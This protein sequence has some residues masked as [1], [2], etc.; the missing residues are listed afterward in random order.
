MNKDLKYLF[1]LV[2]LIFL[3]LGILVVV[4]MDFSNKIEIVNDKKIWES[5]DNNMSNVKSIMDSI[6]DDSDT[7]IWWSLKDVKLKDESYIRFLNQLVAD[8]RM[9]YLNLTSD[10][11]TDSNIMSNYRDKTYIYKSDLVKINNSLSSDNMD[12]NISYDNFLITDNEERREK[13]I[14]AINEYNEILDS[15]LFKNM[16]A[17][18]EDNVLKSYILSVKLEDLAEF[19]ESEYNLYKKN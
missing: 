10:I 14:N 4:N 18:Y 11:Y 5:Y 12:F 13:F 6:T 19:L 1:I 8:V 9:T 7:F 2:G 17:S 3:S 15:E 16:E